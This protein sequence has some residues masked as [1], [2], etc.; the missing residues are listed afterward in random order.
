MRNDNDIDKRPGRKGET[1]AQ[2]IQRARS[3][4]VGVNSIA[5]LD[6]LEASTTPL[7]LVAICTIDR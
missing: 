7:L 1:E 3:E 5:S 6:D 2:R 4:L